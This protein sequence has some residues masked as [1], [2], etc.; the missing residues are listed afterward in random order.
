MRS[1]N[2]NML[3]YLVGLTVLVVGAS[4]AAVPLYRAFCAHTGYGG[5][6]Q[7]DKDGSK[8]ATLTPS[9]KE[10]TVMFNADVSP[11]MHWKFIPSQRQ[12]KIKLGE[13]VLAFYKATNLRD[14]AVTGVATYNVTPMKAG[15]YFHKIQCFCFDEQRLRANETV[16]MPVFFYIDPAVSGQARRDASVTRHVLGRSIVRAGYGVILTHSVNPR[17]FCHTDGD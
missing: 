11:A 4:W 1:T 5:T 12:L 6:T 2:S 3:Q 10:V 17:V 9:K 15:A 8:L 16:D 14:K 7:T 13:P